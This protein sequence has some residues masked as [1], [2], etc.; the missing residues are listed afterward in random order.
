MFISVLRREDRPPPPRSAPA[1]GIARYFARA[2]PLRKLRAAPLRR[3][4]F[5][6]PRSAAAAIM[7]PQPDSLEGW[8]AVRDSAFVEPQPPP[9]L[10]FLVGWNEVEGAFAV[11]CHCRSEAAE[12]A[13]QSWAGLFSA[14]ALRGVH[15]QLAAVCPRL[16]PALPALPPAPPGASGGLWAVLFPGSAAPDEAEVAELCRQ[17]ERYLGWALELCGGRVL[18]DVLFAADSHRDDEYF[19]SL[20]EFRGKA[21][22]GHLARAKEGLRR[23]RALGRGWDRA[24]LLRAG[25][26]SAPWAARAERLL[27]SSGTPLL[28]QK[29]AL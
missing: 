18:L 5:G 27:L 26:G 28:L 10:R 15:R 6:S 21:L 17:L 11:T 9:R 4:S 2:P 1:N 3:P 13:P 29:D 16:E 22:R 24:V 8:V 19:E 20:H 12:R 7:E 23:V 25:R 14:P